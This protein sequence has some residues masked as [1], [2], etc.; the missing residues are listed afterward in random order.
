MPKVKLDQLANSLEDLD[1]P[2]GRALQREPIRHRERFH[3][4]NFDWTNKQKEFIKNN[5][6]MM[7]AADM[8]K[9]LFNNP[10]LTHLYP[11]YKID[12]LHLQ[13]DFDEEILWMTFGRIEVSVPFKN[14]DKF[15]KTLNEIKKTSKKWGKG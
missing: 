10:S 2:Q 9:V 5:A 6:Q 15:I 12:K 3:I 13:P 7:K 4:E 1:N 8:A 11:D 14:L